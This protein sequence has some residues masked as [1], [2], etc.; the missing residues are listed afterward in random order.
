MQNKNVLIALIATVLILSVVPMISATTFNLPVAGG[1]YSTTLTINI[2]ATANGA[3]NMTN[4]TCYY[5][6]SGGTATTYLTQILNES[7]SDLDFTGTVSIAALSDATTYN[8]SCKVQ[9][10]TTLN[11]TYSRVITIDNTDAVPSLS[12]E[13]SDVGMYGLEKL[14]WSSTDATS[15]V[16]S[17]SVSLTS[18][19]TSLCPTQTWTDSTKTS[20][21]IPDQYLACPG[22]Y[23]VSMTVLDYAS[24]SA[25][26]SV[27]F[28]VNAPGAMGGSSV[29]SS[30][31]G[32]PAVTGVISGPGKNSALD[33][34]ALF[35]IALVIIIV[36]F[37]VKKK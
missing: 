1:N 36:Y 10:G 31:S 16:Y 33:A 6:A 11:S 20:Y 37:L 17:T 25:T 32:V 12:R 35:W 14:T 21:I 23:T 15:G 9:N 3:K 5:N 18:P 4:V 19:D 34:K 24:N 8:I 30:S 22:T 28:T 26:S 27:T 29:G 2:T 13:V 7:V